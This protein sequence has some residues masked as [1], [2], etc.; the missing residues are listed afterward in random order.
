MVGESEISEDQSRDLLCFG[1]GLFVLL[2]SRALLDQLSIK[3]V[4]VFGICKAAVLRPKLLKTY[5]SVLKMQ[6]VKLSGSL[7]FSWMARKQGFFLH[8]SCYSFWSFSGF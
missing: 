3:V 5:L 6:L 4:D 2:A 8:Q 7:S 1:S